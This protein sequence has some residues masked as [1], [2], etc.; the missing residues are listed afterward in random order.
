MNL[1]VSVCLIKSR[2]VDLFR[3]EDV[4][5]VEDPARLKFRETILPIVITFATLLQMQWK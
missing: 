3:S 1:K 2:I 4:R 5:I